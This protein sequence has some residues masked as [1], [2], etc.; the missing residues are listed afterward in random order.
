MSGKKITV[1]SGGTSA[2]REVS[3]KSGSQIHSALIELGHEVK[4][5]DL[6]AINQIDHLKKNVEVFIALHGFE[7]ESGILQNKLTNLG[8][9]FFG[10]NAQGCINTWNKANCKKILIESGINTPKFLTT[11]NIK[12]MEFPLETF[13]ENGFYIKPCEEGSSIDTFA[14]K[15]NEEFKSLKQNLVNPDREFIIE[16]A[17]NGREFT[18]SVLKGRCLAPLEIIPANGIY[19]YHAKYIAEDTIIQKAQLKSDQ[20]N[21]LCD[22]A[23]KTCS[24]C[25]CK[26]WARVDVMQNEDGEFYVL[27]INTVPGMTDHSLFP[28]A[29]KISGLS[30]N[31][32]I[33]EIITDA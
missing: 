33:H 26:D 1:L 32:L 30:F 22:I 6:S 2:E 27:E 14:V 11:K 23:L 24:V 15:S 12:T 31:Q 28:A 19:D 9:N 25:E 4:L 10:S 16:E 5:E 18:V 20:I 8:I 3:L 7:G 21:S 29:A 13:L 17:I